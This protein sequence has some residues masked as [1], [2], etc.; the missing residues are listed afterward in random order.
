MNNVE[1]FCQP[2]FQKVH[3]AFVNNFEAGREVGAS[4]AIAIEGELVVD[5]WGGHTDE[6]RTQAWESDTITN[7][8][9]STKTMMFLT[10]VYLADKGLLNLHDKV[11]KHWPEFAQ[12]GKQDIEIRHLMAHTAGIPGFVEP[13]TWELYEDHDY[14]ARLLERQAPWWE[15]GTASGY[16][17]INQ[18]FPL[19]EIVKRI[20]GKS[21]GQVFKENIADPLNADFHIG[22]GSEFDHRCSWIIPMT[23]VEP[24]EIP[25]DSITFKTFTN[26][27]FAPEMAL[28]LGWR[29]AEVGAANGH[30]NA[31]SMAMIQSLMSNGGSFGGKRIF[32][33]E[34]PNMVLEE[35]S[36]G[37]DL[38]IGTPVRFG[39]GYALGGKDSGIPGNRTCYWGGW[40]G[41]LVINDLDRRMTFT[42]AMNRMDVGSGSIGDE[43]GLSMLAAAYSK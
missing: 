25:E 14:C 28:S 17:A 15:P 1:G 39:M 36:N 32:S 3:D 13:M 10:F 4:V 23:G 5:L 35:Q 30:G 2:E 38:V 37:I 29:R 31:R 27:P 7:V 8:W 33:E 24:V 11:S 34:A 16:H 40:G 21:L 43:R 19:G 42:Y 26:P 18:G 41:S 20:T 22:T 6:S 9:S 12:N